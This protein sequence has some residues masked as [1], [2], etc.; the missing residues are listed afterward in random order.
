MNMHKSGTEEVLGQSADT[1]NKEHH[2]SSAAE[3]AEMAHIRARYL[4]RMRIGVFAG[5]GLIVLLA[6][7]LRP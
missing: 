3:E 2:E 4:K 1:V 6:Y 7:V 5:I